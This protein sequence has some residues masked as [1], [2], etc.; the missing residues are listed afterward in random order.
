MVQSRAAV[1]SETLTRSTFTTQ[2]GGDDERRQRLIV[3]EEGAASPEPN[4]HAANGFVADE[5][6]SDAVDMQQR[7][8]AALK[9][10]RDMLAQ[11]L[12]QKKQVD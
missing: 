3:T 4:G 6:Q 8:I 9:Q 1:D 10:Q 2:M 12:Q 7:H 5:D 11:M